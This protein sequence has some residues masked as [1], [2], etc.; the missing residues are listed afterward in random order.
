MC[1]AS[2]TGAD[3]PSW[4]GTPAR[5]VIPGHRPPSPASNKPP[6]EGPWRGCRVALVSSCLSW[7]YSGYCE[8]SGTRRIAGS[9]RLS[10]PWRASRGRAPS[11]PAV[12]TGVHTYERPRPLGPWPRNPGGACT[13]PTSTICSCRERRLVSSVLPLQPRS[14]VLPGSPCSRSGT[15]PKEEQ[16][17]RCCRREPRN[18]RP[19][20][21]P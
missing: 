15:G 4:V 7:G 21:S 12:L 20:L 13:S 2:P 16:A 5:T 14:L 8:A 19:L 6:T 10:N 1:T 3:H 11:R 9:R 18:V 17:D